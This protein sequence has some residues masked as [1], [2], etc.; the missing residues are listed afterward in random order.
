VIER[1]LAHVLREGQPAVFYLHPWEVDPGQPRLPVGPLT[2][3]RHYRGLD[4]CADRL[5]LLMRRFAFRSIR[6]FES[7]PATTAVHA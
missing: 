5:R 3:I 4:V 1:G 6:S 7:A 2:R